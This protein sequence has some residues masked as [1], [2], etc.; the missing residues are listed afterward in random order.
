MNHTYSEAIAQHYV[1]YRPPLHQPILAKAL[2]DHP[3]QS[4]G[5]DIGSGVGNSAL[6][7]TQYCDTV[8][9]IEPNFNMFCQALPHSRIHYQNSNLEDFETPAHKFDLFSFAGTLSYL[10]SPDLIEQLLYLGREGAT[11]II[12]DF[13]IRYEA[14][15][16]GLG[17]KQPPSE[18]SFYDAQ[19]DLSGLPRKGIR[20][21]NAYQGRLNFSCNPKELAHLLLSEQAFHN[22]F[23]ARWGSEYYHRS[24]RRLIE[25]KLG[26]N[27]YPLQANTFFIRYQ[28]PE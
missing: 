18:D 7:L 8:Y 28:L 11:I 9:G 4:M 16:Q 3:R 12:Y 24:L 13:E 19:L 20:K 27:P 23:V 14:V 25:K 17:L 22:D 21:R 5:L 26:E 10:K 6:A 15:F 1:G 2:G